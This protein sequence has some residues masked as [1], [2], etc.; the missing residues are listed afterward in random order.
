M[1]QDIHRKTVNKYSKQAVA[2]HTDLTD[3][4]KTILHLY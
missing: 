2:E 4:M 3:I 1:A